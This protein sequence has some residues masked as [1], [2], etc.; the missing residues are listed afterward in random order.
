MKLFSLGRRLEVGLFICVMLVISTVYLATFYP[1]QRW[2][3][4]FAQYI[5][6]AANLARGQDMSQT[7]YI[8]NRYTPA[9]GPKAYPPGFPVLL[10]PV[11]ALFGLDIRAFQVEI[12]ILQLLA[13]VVAYLLFRRE[14]SPQTALILLIMMGLSPYLINF[15]RDVMSDVPFMLFCIGFLL[16]VEWRRERSEFRHTDALIAALIAFLCYLIRTVG[17]ATLAALAVSDL[18]RTRRLSRFTIWTIIYV[19]PMVIV[20]RLLFGGGQESYLDQFANYDPITPAWNLYWYVLGALNPF[21]A[22]PTISFTQYLGIPFLWAASIILIIYGVYRRGRQSNLLLELFFV[23]Y[24]AIILIWPSWQEMRFL[25][26]VVPLFLLYA[27]F[28]LEGILAWISRRISPQVMKAGAL[29]IGLGILAIYS[30]RSVDVIREETLLESGPYTPSAQS[31]FAFVREQTAPEAVFIFYKPRA[32]AL[33]TD[34]HSSTYPTG[35]SGD[36][37]VAYLDEIGASYAILDKFATLED[38]GPNKSLATLIE[39]QPGAFKIAFSNEQFDV[40]EID[41]DA[42][43]ATGS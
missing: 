7:G 26:P 3:D 20:G 12:L 5:A 2:G 11:Y 18:L 9:L 17:F 31:L 1:D 41:R 29:L 16:W 13:L 35:Q 19:I 38:A 25:Y 15:K 21:M 24:I 23:F 6:Q 39:D 22:G 14:V 40:Y 4:D 37:S 33:Y 42:L 36:V 8:Y 30:V 10:A 32:L 27:G 34:R 28:G 43:K